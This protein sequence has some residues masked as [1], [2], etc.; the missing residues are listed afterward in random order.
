MGQSQVV[1]I[2]GVEMRGGTFFCQKWV[3][4]AESIIK[5]RQK[6]RTPPGGFQGGSDES[7]LVDAPSE[8]TLHL[9]G[10][11]LHLVESAHGVAVGEE[12]TLVASA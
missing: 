9:D 11:V 4:L 7:L 6:S 10:V 3:K 2:T 8:G 5:K 12:G 1:E